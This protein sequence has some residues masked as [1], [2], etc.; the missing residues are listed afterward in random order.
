VSNDFKTA[1][2]LQMKKIGDII[3]FKAIFRKLLVEVKNE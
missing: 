3:F 1:D 2:N